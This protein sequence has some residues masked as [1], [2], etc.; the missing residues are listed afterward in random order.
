MILHAEH[1]I[2]EDDSATMVSW[3]Q[4][5]MREAMHPLLRDIV[6]LLLGYT[7]IIVHHVY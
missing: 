2:I 7:E 3:I 5:A 6:I 4:E 1:L